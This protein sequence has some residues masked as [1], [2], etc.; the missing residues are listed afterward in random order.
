[1][2]F[3]TFMIFIFFNKGIVFWG[4]QN[5]DSFDIWIH[6]CT[7]TLGEGTNMSLLSPLQF[8]KYSRLDSLALAGN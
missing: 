6:F 1:M 2:Y 7:N 3:Q 4:I 8:R 5:P